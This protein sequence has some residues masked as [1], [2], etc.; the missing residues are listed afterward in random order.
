MSSYQHHPLIHS[1]WTQCSGSSGIGWGSSSSHPCQQWSSWPVNTH[2]H[3]SI[4]NYRLQSLEKWLDCWRRT[5]S[6]PCS[7]CWSGTAACRPS[8]TACAT[9]S[10]SLSPNCADFYSDTF[11]R[12]IGWN[13]TASAFERFLIPKE[14][15]F[16]QWSIRHSWLQV[17]FRWHT[18]HVSLSDSYQ[19]AFRDRF[20][21]FCWSGP[22]KVQTPTQE[23]RIYH[24]KSSGI[25]YQYLGPQ[26]EGI[27]RP[28]QTGW[29]HSSTH[30]L[31][32]RDIHYL[33]SFQVLH[34]KANHMQSW[35]STPSYTYYSNQNQRSLSTHYGPK[36]N[37]QV[38]Y[39]CE[40]FQALLNIIHQ[41]W[42]IERNCKP[43]AL[44]ASF[45]WQYNRTA[46]PL[47]RTQGSDRAAW[48]SQCIHRAIQR[49]DGAPFLRFWSPWWRA[50]CLQ[51]PRSC[52][53]P[54]S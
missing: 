39:L 44:L 20:Q 14:S 4:W 16:C 40:L 34:N 17:R 6:P 30:Q 33:L 41:I 50:Q 8:H 13:C 22:C 36:A 48:V 51:L 47:I 24:S 25:A 12:Q 21:E 26:K 43:T 1:C 31:E 11:L 23:F 42:F 7:R 35:E 5:Q 45:S 29:H 46:R 2:L 3:F 52:A 10:R 37:F 38:S 32:P 18:I 15:Y 19:G 54:R 53:S 28:W 27:H 49:L 9:S